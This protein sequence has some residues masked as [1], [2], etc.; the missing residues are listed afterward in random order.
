M[1]NAIG[2]LLVGLSA[3]LM[4]W[5]MN[6]ITDKRIQRELLSAMAESWSMEL[7]EDK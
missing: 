3:K 6:M 2:A 7:K 5:A 1:K 4:S